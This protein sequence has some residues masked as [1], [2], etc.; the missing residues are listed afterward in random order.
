MQES[1]GHCLS[2][3]DLIA[4]TSSDSKG[5]WLYRFLKKIFLFE[6]RRPLTR[7]GG[8]G[9]GRGGGEEEEGEQEEVLSTGS[10]SW[11]GCRP[12][13]AAAPRLQ[14]APPD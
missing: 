8:G 14:I 2:G 6:T 13:S 3:D 12:G 11:S 10:S 1:L 9:G 5:C 7:R 4:V